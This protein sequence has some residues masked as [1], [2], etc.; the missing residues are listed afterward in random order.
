M[1]RYIT[2]SLDGMDGWSGGYPDG[3]VF[4]GWLVGSFLK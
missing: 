1:I 3:W 4:I 2:K